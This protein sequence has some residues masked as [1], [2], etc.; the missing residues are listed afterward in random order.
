MSDGT[1]VSIRALDHTYLPNTPLATEALCGAELTVRAGEL[2]AIIG[3]SG[4]GKSTLVHYVN[5]LLLPAT[6]GH[7][8]I[9]D[10][11]TG[12]PGC[13]LSALRRQVGLVFQ[14]PHQQIVERFVGDD[15]A[16]VP[17]QLGLAGEALRERV[18]WAMAVVGLDFEAFVDRQTFSLSGGEMRRVALAGVLAMRPTLLILD[19]AT[20]GLDPRGR[21]EVHALLRRL[22][23]EEGMAV[24]LISNDMDEVAALAECITVLAEG[25]TVLQGDTRSVFAQRETLRGY[26]LPCP[27]AF[28]VVHALRQRGLPVRG[29]A[30]TAVEAEEAVWQAMT[31]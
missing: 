2:A 20:T 30:L 15:I 24:L 16:Y 4:A 22:R 6:R 12:A 26:G 9:L 14:Y 7:V 5:G 29:Q 11:D 10:Q 8:T 13:D 17:R 31:P 3:P 28:E 27:T 19:E 1:L 23:E 21:E 18:R 25:R